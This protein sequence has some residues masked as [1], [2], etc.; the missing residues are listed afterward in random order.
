[1]KYLTMTL[2]WLR[3]I[4][5]GPLVDTV[6]NWCRAPQM[7]RLE[8]PT[9]GPEPAALS[10]AGVTV[11]VPLSRAVGLLPVADLDLAVGA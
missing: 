11:A 6:G 4:R 8:L 7:Q 2:R 5:A 10:P 3:I 1:M 9:V